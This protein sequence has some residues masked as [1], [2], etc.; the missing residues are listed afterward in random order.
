MSGQTYCPEYLRRRVYTLNIK[1]ECLSHPQ[2]TD[3]L[4]PSFESR[5]EYEYE[6]RHLLCVEIWKRTNRGLSTQK[7]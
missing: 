2:N 6:K 7:S 5:G 1:S 4:I 3:V